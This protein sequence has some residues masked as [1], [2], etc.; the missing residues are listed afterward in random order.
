MMELAKK[1]GLVESP[2]S[3]ELE[4]KTS[5]AQREQEADEGKDT[6]KKLASSADR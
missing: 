6:T 3:T 4:A 2:S 1:A 5:P